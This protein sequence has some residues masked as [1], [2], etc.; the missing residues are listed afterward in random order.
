[1]I[2]LF[3]GC[4]ASGKDIVRRAFEDATKYEHTC[5]TRFMLS[6]F[7]YAQYFKRPLFTDTR[8]NREYRNSIGKFLLEFRPLIVYLRADVGVLNSR[9]EQRGEKVSEQPDA[10]L[11][12][13]LY[14]TLFRDLKLDSSPRFLTID[15]SF[16]PDLEEV[17]GRIVSK[18]A[19][20]E[21]RK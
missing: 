12:M 10:V 19:K 2:L 15:T 6:Q 8:K 7:V 5:V 1:M 14:D 9:I 13:H 17:A 20:L 18:V 16:N 4:D 11:M 21:R 3:E